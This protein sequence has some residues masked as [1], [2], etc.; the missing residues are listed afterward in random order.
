VIA[1]LLG[2]CSSSTSEHAK[3]P[4]TNTVRTADCTP[5]RPKPAPQASYTID[6]KGVPRTYRLALP[7][8]YDGTKAMPM[9]LLFHGWNS[10]A[11]AFDKETGFDT[12]GASRGYIVVTPDGASSPKTWN[13]IPG[14]SG[15]TA[16]DFGFVNT[17]VSDLETRL[18]VDKEHV[19]AAG[20]S[21]GSAFVG[22]LVCKPPYSFAGVAMVEASI[23]SSCP[24]G[25]TYS[26][27]S[28]HGTADA[29]VPY[30]GGTGQ[31]QTVPIPPVK[32]TIASFAAR[33]ACERRPVID[34]PAPGVE[35]RAYPHC[36]N[37]HAVA[38]LSLVGANHPWAG[39]LHARASEHNVPAA[40][41]SATDAILDFF[42][43][44]TSQ[45]SPRVP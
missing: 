15:S 42:D 34:R 44:V 4:V 45:R 17:L 39:G 36:A 23:P 40:Q 41:F 21:A 31:G 20:H 10:S 28:I 2:A 11:A 27:V 3:T 33:D 26:V 6:V 29:A 5:A 8:Q 16:D 12:T 18:C 37:G 22:F 32:N 25:V 7:K 1:G 38:L 24:A 9:V 35:R 30:T 43:D 19:Y 14:V 13:F